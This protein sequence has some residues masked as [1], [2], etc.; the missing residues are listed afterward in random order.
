MELHVD[1]SYGEGGGQVLRSALAVALLSGRT[2]H[3]E[4]IRAGRTKPGL[5]AQHL[6]AV[7]AAAVVCGAEID[8]DRLSSQQLRFTPRH[9]PL[10]GEYVVDVA[11]ARRGG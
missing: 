7:R 11:E 9:P 8:G 2:L 4:H 3:I 5:M 6:S 1:G 10:A